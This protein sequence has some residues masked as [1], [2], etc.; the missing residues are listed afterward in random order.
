[1]INN[2]SESGFTLLEMM[3]V[4][5]LIGV[6]FGLVSVRL[7]I[8]GRERSRE[9]RRFKAYLR[10]QHARALTDGRTFRMTFRPSQNR[11]ERSGD[12]NG[13]RFQHWTIQGDEPLEFRFAPNGVFGEGPVTLHHNNRERRFTVDRLEGLV[14]EYEES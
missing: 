11:V 12:S 9:M 6:F 14:E 5:A 4:I 3:V 2:H 7:D 1:M 13:F 10:V 8:F